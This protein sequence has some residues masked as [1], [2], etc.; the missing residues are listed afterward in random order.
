[1]SEEEEDPIK[2]L[3]VMKKLGDDL[4][5]ANRAR[6][7]NEKKWRKAEFII[8]AAEEFM[9]LINRDY[10]Y[11]V[12]NVSYW[13]AYGAK[14]VEEVIGKTI[15]DQWGDVRGL[16]IKGLIDRAFDGETVRDANWYNFPAVGDRY[17]EVTYYP[18]RCKEGDPI[19]H[20]VVVT[21][22]ET[23]KKLIEEQL[24][25][26]CNK[27]ET[28]CKTFLKFLQQSPVAVFLKDQRLKI[29]HASDKYADIAQKPIS[30]IL[31]RTNVEI[32]GEEV[33][34]HLEV[35]DNEVLA[36][37]IHDRQYEVL[38]RGEKYITKKFYLEVDGKPMVGGFTIGPLKPVVT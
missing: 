30:E 26:K 34:Q 31:G 15:F 27:L 25:I 37:K 17:F 4:I 36:N 13:A 35:H 18:F 19:S 28:M 29:I 12:A 5:A 20:V 1:M 24:T 9:T 33:G 32:W 23:D 3:S 22:D 38:I 8:N 11:E 10:V 14:S 6:V 16:E 21:H 7:E 2:L